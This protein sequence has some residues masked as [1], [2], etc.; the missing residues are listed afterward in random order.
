MR[1]EVFFHTHDTWTGGNP[2][3]E[4]LPFIKDGKREIVN[5]NQPKFVAELLELIIDSHEATQLAN[6]VIENG[7][8][9]IEQLGYREVHEEYHD[10][11][12]RYFK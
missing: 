12:F 7:K 8:T 11:S 1:I 5:F 3:N 9:L 10:S 6:L 2:L 4:G